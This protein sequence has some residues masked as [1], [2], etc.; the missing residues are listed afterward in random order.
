MEEYIKNI[1][2]RLKRYSRQL[3][4]VELFIEKPW[5]KY[6][7]KDRIE[8]TFERD[9][10]LIISINGNAQTGS[11]KLLSTGKLYITKSDGEEQ[12]NPEFL[13]EDIFILTK[14]NNNQ[15]IQLF[16]NEKNISDQNIEQYIENTIL[17][18][19]NEGKISSKSTTNYQK[20]LPQLQTFSIKENDIFDIKNY[21]SL[22][23]EINKLKKDLEQFPTI[24]YKQIITSYAKNHSLETI[25]SNE[26]PKLCRGIIEGKLNIKIMEQLFSDSKHNSVFQSQLLAYINEVLG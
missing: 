13:S 5:I 24:Y 10:S 19:Q 11:W 23:E 18:Y 9:K 15:N 22:I 1:L 25:W 17:I 12:L 3:S 2:P 16:I 4:A 21:P 8:Y 6:D 20:K 14:P 7:N 26:N